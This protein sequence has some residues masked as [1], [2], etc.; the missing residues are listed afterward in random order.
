MIQPNIEKTRAY[1][2]HLDPE[3]ICS[4]ADC[5]NYCARV[6]AA[7]PEV[8]RYLVSLGVDI[9]RPFE[10]SPF[11]NLCQADVH[12]LDRDYTWRRIGMK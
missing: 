6:K 4:C 7:Y 9:E 5:R 12:L 8:K 1:Y 10:L 3:N 2:Q 11:N